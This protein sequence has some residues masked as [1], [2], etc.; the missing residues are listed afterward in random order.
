MSLLIGQLL[1]IALAN[2][3]VELNFLLHS[4]NNNTNAIELTPPEAVTAISVSKTA[5]KASCNS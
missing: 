4:D 2:Q 5:L 1:P 3:G